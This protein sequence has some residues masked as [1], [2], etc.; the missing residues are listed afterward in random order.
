MWLTIKRLLLILKNKFLRCC[1]LWVCV[2]RIISSNRA[3]KRKEEFV[4]MN[5]AST[6]GRTTFWW[7]GRASSPA[8]G[9]VCFYSPGR[10]ERFRIHLPT[11]WLVGEIRVSHYA[12]WLGGAMARGLVILASPR[13]FEFYLLAKAL[14][15]DIKL[16]ISVLFYAWGDARIWVHRNY[17][18]DMRLTSLEAGIQSIAHF[19][20]FSILNSPQGRAWEAVSSG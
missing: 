8:H 9:C 1:G 2:R 13:G 14:K 18:G 16:M 15:S 12:C 4:G 11:R 7:S 5:T 10:E 6:A 3:V 20:C 19:L 17:S